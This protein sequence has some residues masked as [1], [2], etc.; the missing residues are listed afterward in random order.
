M[1]AF[2]TL[3]VTY[4]QLPD[5]E[6]KDAEKV[7]KALLAAFAVDP[8]VAYEQFSGRRLRSVESPDVFLADLRRLAS[9]FGGVSEKALAC[10]FVA[11]LPDSVRQLLRAGSRLENL[12][13]DQILARARAVL[14]DECPAGVANAC[15]GA[16]PSEETR[17]TVVSGRRCYACG[18]QSFC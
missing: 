15:L 11:G 14:I 6:K 16:R 8:F 18:P 4:L 5:D 2:H 10:A 1:P 3:A 17:Q 7:K 9:L 13:L 12:G